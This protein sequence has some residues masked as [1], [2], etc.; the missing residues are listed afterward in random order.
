MNTL[1]TQKA[2]W[3]AGEGGPPGPQVQNS[4][5]TWGMRAQSTSILSSAQLEKGTVGLS[6]NNPAKGCETVLTLVLCSQA[7]HH[8]DLWAE[9]TGRARCARLTCR[10]GV[11]SLIFFFKSYLA[12]FRISGHLRPPSL[13]AA[14]SANLVPS[15]QLL[16][17]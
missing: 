12:A 2:E 10:L 1:G 9:L 15:K 8:G 3:T 7:W 13:S 14:P 5:P 17:Q 4:M 6:L 16:L 11:S